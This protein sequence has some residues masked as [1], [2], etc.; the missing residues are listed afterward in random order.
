[1]AVFL[2]VNVRD[3]LS[4]NFNRRKSFIRSSRK[5]SVFSSSFR[6]LS[7]VNADDYKSDTMPNEDLARLIMSVRPGGNSAS[8]LRNRSGTIL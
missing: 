2:Y 7:T 1:M 3:Q 8:R 4:A 6:S 5:F